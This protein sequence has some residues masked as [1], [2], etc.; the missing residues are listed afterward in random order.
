MPECSVSGA[1]IA[2]RLNRRPA[3][4]LL[5]MQGVWTS[6]QSF[7]GGRRQ[8]D[9][10]KV[11]ELPRLGLRQTQKFCVIR[12]TTEHQHSFSFKETYGNCLHLRAKPKILLD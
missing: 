3:G 2:R 10:D 11:A 1:R 6:L 5:R 8:S 7:R 9:C 12:V 4:L